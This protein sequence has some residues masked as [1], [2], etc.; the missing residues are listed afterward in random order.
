MSQTFQPACVAA[1]TSTTRAVSSVASRSLRTFQ[2]S[3]VAA[4]TSTARAVS[5][6]AVK[7][8]RLNAMF[9]HR[10]FI[11]AIAHSRAAT[12]G[13]R[14]DR[15]TGSPQLSGADAGSVE[16]TA[17]TRTRTVAERRRGGQL[18]GHDPVRRPL[19]P[20]QRVASASL[21]MITGQGAWWAHCSLTDPS[22]RPANPPCPRV[23]TTRR[24]AS[25][26]SSRRT[27]AARPS[28]AT[29]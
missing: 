17:R 16:G 25:C 21:T 24:S 20:A 10:P 29:R 3:C 13:G 18:P 12:I 1:N 5:T 4:N 11:C 14:T 8:L 2:P 26:A 23:P 15:R 6:V 19:P 27:R 22:R 28:R 9:S 7:S